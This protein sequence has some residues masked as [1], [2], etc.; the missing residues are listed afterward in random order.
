MTPIAAPG[1]DENDAPALVAAADVNVTA[2]EDSFAVYEDTTADIPGSAAASVAVSLDQPPAPASTP[3]PSDDNGFEIY[4][5]TMLLDPAAV[6]VA[7][8]VEVWVAVVTAAS[9]AA[10]SDS[11][12]DRACWKA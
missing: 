12:F 7:A 3:A 1:A 6:A 10:P 9:G 5:D 4:Q 2:G 11:E 8:A